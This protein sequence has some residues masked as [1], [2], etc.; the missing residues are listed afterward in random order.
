MQRQ[1]ELLSR[2]HG[3]SHVVVEVQLTGVSQ[4]HSHTDLRDQVTPGQVKGFL[5]LLKLGE[6]SRLVFTLLIIFEGLLHFY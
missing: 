4:V 6:K 3:D 1:S 5:C 2:G